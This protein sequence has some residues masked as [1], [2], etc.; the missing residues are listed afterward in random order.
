MANEK[1]KLHVSF[2]HGDK[3]GVGK[4]FLAKAY[5]SH[6]LSR[7]MPVTG[8]DTDTRNPDVDRMFSQYCAV[9]KVD[10]RQE[11]GWSLLFSFLEKEAEGNVVISL[12]AGIGGEA[13]SHGDVLLE[14]LKVLEIP[15]TTWWVMSNVLDSTNLIQHSINKGSGLVDGAVAVQNQ[16]FGQQFPHW[17]GSKTRDIF[18]KRRGQ[19]MVMPL[20]EPEIVRTCDNA[21]M[22]LS[23]AVQR[24]AHPDINL[25]DQIKLSRWIA[26]MDTRFDALKLQQVRPESALSPAAA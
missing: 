25:Y 21:N 17:Q 12:P 9:Y 14:A 1:N 18:M 5:M 23:L 7:G 6:L 16:F 20:L 24:N 11:R 8:I 10:L 22:M 26:E 15:V 4:S 3:G 2:F 13:E 19:E